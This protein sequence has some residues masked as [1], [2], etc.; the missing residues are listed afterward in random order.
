MQYKL[1]RKRMKRIILRVDK[2]GTLRV[3]APHWVDLST[4]NDFVESKREWIESQQI[5]IQNANIQNYQNGAEISYFDKIFTLRFYPSQKS[6]ITQNG[7]FLDIGIGDVNDVKKIKQLIISWYQS[8]SFG[9]IYAII[10]KYQTFINRKVEKIRIREMTSRWGS[11][12]TKKATITLNSL[13]FSKPKICFE[14]VLL[15]ELVHLLH[16]NH[17]KA[18]YKDLESCMPDWKNIK[19]LLEEK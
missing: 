2:N 5:K 15:H 3:S 9:D 16:P 6:K 10:A 12:N 8:H 11:C 14:Y 17:S 4:I 13:L 18:F 7:D 19:K 1:Q